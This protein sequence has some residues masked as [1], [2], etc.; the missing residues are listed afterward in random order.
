MGTD[1][2]TD[3]FFPTKINLGVGEALRS[4]SRVPAFCPIIIYWYLIAFN[5]SYAGFSIKDLSLSITFFIL[6]ILFPGYLY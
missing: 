2:S 6:K 4:S 5:V 3:L 1:L